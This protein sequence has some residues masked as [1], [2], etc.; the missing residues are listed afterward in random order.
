MDGIMFD[1][2]REQS[3][4]SGDICVWRVTACPRV[5]GERPEG[6]PIFK[7]FIFYSHMYI[8]LLLLDDEP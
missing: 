6:D 4:S 3:P 5:E 1:H 2:R 8:K 7:K